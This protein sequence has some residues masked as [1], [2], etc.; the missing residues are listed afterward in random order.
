MA[1]R[2]KY[3]GKGR[4]YSRGTT[5]SGA[6]I[7]QICWDQYT[8]DGKRIQRY[9][10]VRGGRR[11]AQRRLHEILGNLAAYNS[12][13]APQAITVGDYLGSWVNRADVRPYTRQK[14]RSIID[15]HLI[16][17]LGAKLLGELTRADLKNYY[18]EA[19]KTG[20]KDGRGKGLASI[21]VRHHHELVHKALADAAMDGLIPTNPAWSP[22]GQSIAP[23]GNYKKRQDFLP[24]ELIVFLD[25]ARKYPKVFPILATLAYSGARPGEILPLRFCDILRDESALLIDQSVVLLTGGDYQRESP[26]TETGNRKIY[27]PSEL[28]NILDDHE[29]ER[30]EHFRGVGYEIQARDPVFTRDDGS[31][32]RRDHIYDTF[33]KITRT[34]N[35][36]GF[37]LYSLRHTYITLVLPH[38]ADAR[39]VSEQ[40]GHKEFSF[41]LQR[42]GHLR[43]GGGK[44][45]AAVF[46]DVLA[47]AREKL[48]A[49]INSGESMERALPR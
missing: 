26:K 18:D 42:Y 20:R 21:T 41:T 12:S 24:E 47:A 49:P 48:H 5:K 27:V 14:Y 28:L 31:L 46:A 29:T 2:K 15:A 13:N 35:L 44:Y 39:L 33:K 36:D 37:T 16:P 22:K 11:E 19:Q 4:I 32:I 9:Q 38:I 17:S 34:L 40:A 25:E 45:V 43:P 30:R 3:S 7:W 1:N 23:K 10:N 6:P 8:S